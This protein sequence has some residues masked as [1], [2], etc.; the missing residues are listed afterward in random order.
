MTGEQP[1]GTGP[2][3]SV[4]LSEP[5]YGASIGTAWS[6]FW[7]KYATF[8]GRASRSEFWWWFLIQYVVAGILTTAYLLVG[9][10]SQ[11]A[12]DALGVLIYLIFAVWSVATVI[13][14][15]ALHFR[16]LHDA[17]RSAGWIFIVLV[18]F[19]GGIILIV[20]LILPA[21][22]AGERFDFHT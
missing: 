18:P 14:T 1:T 16:R 19:I 21:N 6:R 2:R 10:N 15:I 5:F 13:P 12:G 22:R 20:L 4:P 17:N 3:P 8:T 9:L 7:K 11:P